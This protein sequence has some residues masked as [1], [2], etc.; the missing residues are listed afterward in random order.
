M[1]QQETLG[2]AVLKE[3]QDA[4]DVVAE[5]AQVPAGLVMRIEGPEI[6]VF[7]S[8][9]TQGNPYNPGDREHLAGSGLYCER[10]INTREKLLVP[11]ARKDPEWDSNPDIKLSMYSYMGFPILQPDGEVF[12]TLCILDSRENGY[13]PLIERM[14]LRMKGLMEGHLALAFKNLQLEARL[15]EIKTLQGIIPICCNCKQIRDDEGF[16]NA[17]EVYVGS[18]TE[19]IFSHSLCPDCQEKLYPGL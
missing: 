14:M 4:V 12:G 16:W 15:A 7:L 1:E 10:V 13:S 6:A 18:R 8:S 17:V 11:D 19:A 5:L 9:Q 3:W 2:D